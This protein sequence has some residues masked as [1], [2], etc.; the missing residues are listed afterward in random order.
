[1][2]VDFDHENM[3]EEELIRE[4]TIVNEKLIKAEEV[5]TDFLSNIKNEINNPMT[6]ILG[7]L[8][9]MIARPEDFEG[10]AK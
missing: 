8:K 6:S 10:N 9:T 5:K 4:L 7:L 1:M 2:K 3:S